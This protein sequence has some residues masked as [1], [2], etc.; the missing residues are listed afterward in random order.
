MILLGNKV[1]FLLLHLFTAAAITSSPS[2]DDPSYAKWGQLAVQKAKSQY[3]ASV[4]DYLHIGRYKISPSIDEERFKLWL[5]KN[6]REFGVYV[7]IR[8]DSS[9]EEFISIRFQQTP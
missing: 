2:S 8:L 6:G 4:I 9:T 5:R 7:F 3:E 1:S